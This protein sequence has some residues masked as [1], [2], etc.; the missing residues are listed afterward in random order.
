MP[1]VFDA[2][3]ALVPRREH[4]FAGATHPA[5]AN[6]V[7]LFGGK[8]TCAVLLNAALQHPNARAT[9]LP[10]TV[11]YAAPIADGEFTIEAR[12]LRTN[13]S[14]QHWSLLLS[15]PGGV[16]ASASAVFALRRDTWSAR[17]SGAAGRHAAV[18]GTC[19]PCR[20]GS[21][22]MGALAT[23]CASMPG[24]MPDRWDGQEQATSESRMW[25][26]D[27]PPR[28]ARLR[29]AGG[30]QRRVLPRIFIRRGAS[31]RS[32]PSRSPPTS[33]PTRRSS[34]SRAT[35]TARPGTGAELPQ[36]LLIKAEVWSDAGWL[37]ASTQ[38]MVYPGSSG[39]SGRSASRGAP[40]I[41]ISQSSVS[42][43]RL[44]ARSK[45]RRALCA[46]GRR[47]SAWSVRAGWPVLP[48]S[49]AASLLA[50]GSSLTCAEQASP[51]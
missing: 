24:T 51:P 2:A 14:T 6:M 40:P 19:R 38:Q 48:V 5:Y 9:R 28:P 8:F 39:W 12:P 21:A 11:N 49:P 46:C 30:D 33:T 3:I 43:A 31:R 7:G 10:L 41:R 4:T 17:E 23:T 32:A 22:A 16:C 20:S 36:R 26:R 50:G 35:A 42:I 37:L 34:H 1:H 18:R 29:R 15:Q 13:R 27:E 45:G 25:V 47:G 44:F